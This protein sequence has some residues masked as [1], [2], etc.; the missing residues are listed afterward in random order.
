M[1][2]AGTR[3]DGIVIGAGH[4]GLVCAALLAR[5]GRRILVLEARERAGG[6]AVTREFSPGF[7]A[8]TAAHVLYGLP[9]SLGTELGLERHGLRAAAE[10]LPTTSL[11]ADGGCADVD[12]GP[13]A[14]EATAR[15]AFDRRIMRFAAF[16]AELQARVPPRLG[17]TDWSDR[18]ELL[19]AGFGLRRL[20]RGDMRELLRIGAMNAYDLLDETF[21]SEA[22]KG[23]LAFDA[24]LGTNFGPRSPGS[25]FTW[26]HRLA[27]LSAGG[28]RGLWFP[29]GGVG[30]LSAALESAARA[31]GATLRTGAPVARIL[32][33]GD[34]ASGVELENGERIEAPFVV[35]GADPK[36]TLLGLLGPRH[37]DAG[38]V[39]TVRHLRNTGLAAKLHLALDGA[40]RF[41]GVD[42][43]RMRGRLLIAPSM[44]YV[45]RAFDHSK[46]G[47]WSA[48][49]AMEITLPSLTDPSLAPA[50]AQVLSAIVQYVPYTVAGGWDAERPR[51]LEALLDLL[52]RYAPG[53][54]GSVV[55]AELIAPPDLEREHGI[56]GGHWHHLELALDQFHLLRPTPGARGHATPLPGLYLCGAGC[57]PGGGV[58]GLPGRNAAQFILRQSE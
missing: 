31:A 9:A 4:N 19:R 14:I 38:F 42:H 51:L 29:V 55:A 23:A 48:A 27:G 18:F 35:S 28:G 58:T 2:A 43:E 44:G 5:A 34:R 15:A 12:P 45:E 33:D 10:R 30:A 16:L 13:A 39:R 56:A 36:T 37:L 7:R 6:A 25:V 53:L 8:S 20:G 52:E 32:V 46:Y 21:E 3:Y 11:L 57:H 24:V 26:L 17:T 49:P 50:G 47:E 1:S 40:P 22:L 41:A 54:R